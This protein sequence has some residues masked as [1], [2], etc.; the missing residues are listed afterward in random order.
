MLLSYLAH[1]RACHAKQTERQERIDNLRPI[2]HEPVTPNDTRILALSVADVVASVHAQKL[3]P[4]DVLISYGKQALKAHQRTNCLTEVMIADAEGWAKTCNRS[5][6][7]AGMPVSL[8]DE[9]SV[10]G[11]DACIGYSAWIGKPRQHDSAIVR[12][13]RDAGAVPFLKTNLPTTLLS[14]ECGNDVFGTTT[15]PYSEHHTCGGSTGG[16]SALIACGGSRIGVGSDVG[17]SLRVPAHW[18]GI[19]SIKAS[20]RRFCVTGAST[21][22]PGQEGIP[23]VNSPLARTL[24]DLEYFFKAVI[25]M[26]PW[27]YDHSVLPIPWRDIRL[28]TEEPLKWGVIWDDGLVRPSPACDRALRLVTVALEKAGHSV[29]TFNPPSL[30][31]GYGL[32]SKLLMGD[33]GDTVTAPLRTGER[34]DPGIGGIVFVAGLPRWIKKIYAWYMRY[35]RRDEVVAGLLESSRSINIAEYWA[36]VA[37]REEYRRKWHDA[38]QAQ[39]LDFLLTVPNPL[40]ALPHGGIK[41]A[42]NAI[43][44]GSLFNLLDYSAGIIPVTR[45]DRTE[46][47]RWPGFK[48]RNGIEAGMY[49]LYDA[50]SMHGLPLGIQVVG[51][52]LEEEKVFAGMK[53][54]EGLLRATPRSA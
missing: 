35:I 15:N 14:Y 48:P 50:N 12:L 36:L 52:C 24:E 3:D 9:M 23:H 43:G 37:Q 17:G 13:L 31:E 30:S 29:V 46:D 6:P 21:S 8:K 47:A 38:W 11:W 2:Y 7:L 42:I 18:C 26:E 49:E 34:L 16:E 32:W 53:L 20:S 19:Y 41:H 25:S 10:K 1:R 44:Y 45:V 4:A 39:G 27:T 51:Q 33:M 22:A 40:P 28:S 5:G 54:V